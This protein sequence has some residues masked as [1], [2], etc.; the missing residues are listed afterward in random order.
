MNTLQ[1]GALPPPTPP[2]IHF[3]YGTDTRG[4]TTS[5][6]EA[7]HVRELIEQVLLT[8]PGERVMRPTFGGS[9][10]QRV[11]EPGGPELL[12][13]TQYLVQATLSQE[14]GH[15]ITLD[16]LE[17]ES[18]DATLVVTVTWT[19]LRTGQQQTSAVTIPGGT[20]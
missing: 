3:P 11:F 19:L 5:C 13:S 2:R 16:A 6:P 14:L 20:S 17:L 7:Q 1:P 4:R 10:M 15:R 8:A 18:R 9:L 12:A